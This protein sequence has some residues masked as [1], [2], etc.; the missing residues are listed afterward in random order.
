MN[1]VVGFGVVGTKTQ[2][3]SCS[4]LAWTSSSSSDVMN[5]TLKMPLRGNSTMT[6]CL[7]DLPLSVSTVSLNVL[8]PP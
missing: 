1:P 5:P 6:T 4:V 7:N 2:T 8:A 3:T